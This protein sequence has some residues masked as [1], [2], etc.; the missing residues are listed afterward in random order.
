MASDVDFREERERELLRYFREM[1]DRQQD[2]LLRRA[3]AL[4]GGL[5]VKPEGLS[6]LQEKMW[7]LS[8]G[9]SPSQFRDFAALLFVEQGY[10]YHPGVGAPLT[11][12][13]DLMFEKGRSR[14]IVQ[15]RHRGANLVG[16]GAVRDLLGLM[17][18]TGI[19]KGTLVTNLDFTPG[20][21][22]FA[23]DINQSQRGQ[24]ITL[25]N[26]AKIERWLRDPQFA[27][28][29]EFLDN[30]DSGIWQDILKESGKR[31]R[32]RGVS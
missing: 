10:H 32:R 6:P 18:K 22:T 3:A 31:R 13:K 7:A 12:K 29:R 28:A 30:P 14:V 21:R 4:V 27:R 23:D 24:P 26:A 16:E 19:R 5:A 25:V 2:L 9:L 15:C 8:T 1:D 11:T 20:A 17:G